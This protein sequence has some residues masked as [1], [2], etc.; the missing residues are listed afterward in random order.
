MTKFIMKLLTGIALTGLVFATPVLADEAKTC[1]RGAFVD[2]QDELKAG[3]V[4]IDILSA[5]ETAAIVAKKGPPPGIAEG[6]TPKFVILSKD[7]MGQFIVLDKDG[8]IVLVQPPRPAPVELI[9]K[10]IGRISA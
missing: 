4:K 10:F 3:G 6:E 2:V 9:E 5:E 8:C 7:G 1:P